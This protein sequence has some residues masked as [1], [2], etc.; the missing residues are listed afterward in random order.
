MK[1]DERIPRKK[2]QET[3]IRLNP[4]FLVEHIEMRP[5]ADV[6]LPQ[7]LYYGT[8]NII[9]RPSSPFNMRLSYLI[10]RIAGNGGEIS[11]TALRSLRRPGTGLL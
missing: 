7:V 2:F 6:A 1:C 4:D 5:D 9:R 11:S 3:L 8:I 10:L